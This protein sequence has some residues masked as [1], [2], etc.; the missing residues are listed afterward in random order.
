MCK[1]A[2]LHNS[3]VRNRSK[4]DFCLFY[5][6]VGIKKKPLVFISFRL[7]RRL[8]EERHDKTDKLSANAASLDGGEERYPG[9]VAD[10]QGV[11]ARYARFRVV[12]D[13]R[14]CEHREYRREIRDNAGKQKL[15]AQ[16]ERKFRRMKLTRRIA[17]V[18]RLK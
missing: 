2:T 15:I 14:A 3:I 1:R 10:E 8:A 6:I 4:I 13:T 11:F 16:K 9:I 5:I 12:R 17:S 7:S 18:P